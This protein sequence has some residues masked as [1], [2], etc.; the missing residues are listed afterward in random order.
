MTVAWLLLRAARGG[1]GGLS[2]LMRKRLGGMHGRQTPLPEGGAA[3]SGL[4]AATGSMLAGSGAPGSGNADAS[5]LAANPTRTANPGGPSHGVLRNPH[6]G[7][8]S[9]RPS[10][11]VLGLIAFALAV[12]AAVLTYVVPAPEYPLEV[13]RRES[14]DLAGVRSMVI[15]AHK[16]DVVFATGDDAAVRLRGSLRETF[17]QE[18][19]LTVTRQG[20]VM[21]ITA[22]HREGLSWGINPWPVLEV[23]VPE[24][25]S[26]PIAVEARE[27]E[28]DP[29]TLPDL[30]QRRMDVRATGRRR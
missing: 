26:L 29:G 23:T 17:A 16:V 8:G 24:D 6:P 25:A 4:S 1:M 7:P 9:N 22:R 3:E 10:P 12:V 15:T 2:R 27:A 13:D 11:L 28:V 5:G 18:I 30:L 14:L 19:D 21:Q 20:D